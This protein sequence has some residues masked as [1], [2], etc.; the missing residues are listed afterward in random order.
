MRPVLTAAESA[1]MYIISADTIEADMIRYD[2]PSIG[3]DTTPI[4]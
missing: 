3:S 4:R 1:L 2:T